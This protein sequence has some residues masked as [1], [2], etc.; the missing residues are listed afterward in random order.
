[1]SKLTFAGL[2]SV[3]LIATLC[4]VLVVYAEESQQ[5]FDGRPM[6]ETLQIEP[7][8]MTENSSFYNV[9]LTINAFAPDT[10]NKIQLNKN[11]TG[12][13]TCVNGTAVDTDNPLQIKL[14]SGG[15]NRS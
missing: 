14:N 9:Y 4:P 8:A 2:I 7:K 6:L 5:Q 11:I 1:M 15:L 10:I 3:L 12:L 13:T